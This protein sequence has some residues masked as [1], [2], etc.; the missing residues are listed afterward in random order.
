MNMN[1]QKN[2]MD[3]LSGILIRCSWLTFAL[4]LVWFA[5]YTLGGDAVYGMQARWFGL[6]RHDY[7]L[8]SFGGM[9]F[10]KICA[11]LFFL[12]PYVAVRLV[13][14]AKGNKA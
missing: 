13:L 2:L 5:F 14:R 12:F 10:V 3:K 11:I 1:E 8:L 9:A 7:A 4:L 6:S